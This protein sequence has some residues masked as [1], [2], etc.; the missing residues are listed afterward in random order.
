MINQLGVIGAGTMGFGIAFQFAINGVQTTLTDISEEMLET[1]KGKFH[2][3]LD[4]FRA[5]GYD[6]RYSDQEV[7]SHISFTTNINDLADV[8][9]II[10]SVSENLTLKQKLFKQL[11]DICAEHT[12]LASNTSS[13][14]L[15]DITV[16]V[17]KHK[18]RTILTH[19]F[20]PAHI[21]PL[22]ELLRSNETSDHVF[23][24]VKDFLES[25]NKVTIE[26]KKEID[27]LVA[28]RIQV[29]IVREA[30]ALIEDGV[31]SEEDLDTAIFQGPGFR[32]SSSGLLKILDFGGLDIWKAVLD[33]L[34]SKIESNVREFKAIEERVE[35]GA[36]GVKAGK[37]FYEYPGKSFDGYVKERDSQLIKHLLNTQ[38]ELKAKEEVNL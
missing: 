20:N 28:N 23:N 31:V 36:I 35:S 16:D 13:L 27:G 12:I 34:Q 9:L 38:S 3:Y 11:D 33:G 29:A 2:I 14:K 17:K 4:L 26:V 5:E 6:I 30:L 7:L 32:F 24:E 15:S 21:V 37:G 1:A 25:N 19:F 10:E 18:D 8:D 22:V